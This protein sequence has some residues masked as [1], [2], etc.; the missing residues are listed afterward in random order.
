MIDPPGPARTETDGV[1]KRWEYQKSERV[2]ETE[3]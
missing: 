2:E 1:R 3:Y